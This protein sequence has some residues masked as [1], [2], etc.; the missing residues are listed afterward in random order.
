MLESTSAPNTT[1]SVAASPIVIVP[2][3]KVVVPVTIVHGG[4]DT[5]VPVIAARHTKSLLPHAD[6]RIFP[7][8][9]HVSV[10]D[11]TIDACREMRLVVV[12]G[13]ARKSKM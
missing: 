12:N 1:L 3:L 9:G 7:E 13:G 5:I 4:K 2:P 6:L 10:M 11:L 8:C